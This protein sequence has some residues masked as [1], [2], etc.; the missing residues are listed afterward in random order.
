MA[1]AKDGRTLRRRLVGIGSREQEALD[2]FLMIEIISEIE[3]ARN[4]CRFEE[5]GVKREDKGG[6]CKS[7]VD[8]SISVKIDRTLDIF[9][10]KKSL[11]VLG[12]A[13]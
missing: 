9:A 11:K 6:H 12:P 7:S 2:D 13:S 5:D 1:G 4:E 10:T 3:A 8:G